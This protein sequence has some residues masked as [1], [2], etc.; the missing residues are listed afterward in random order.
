MHFIAG[1]SRDLLGSLAIFLVV[2]LNKKRLRVQKEPQPRDSVSLIS[3]IFTR[4]W[5]WAFERLWFYQRPHFR[6][7]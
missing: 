2:M 4:F 5:S 6:P 3:V 1:T 7:L